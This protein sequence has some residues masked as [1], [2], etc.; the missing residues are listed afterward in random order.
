MDVTVGAREVSSGRITLTAGQ[1]STVT[2]TVNVN[3]VQV[4]ADGTAVV[5]LTT[6]GTAPTIDGRQ[7]YEIP[8]NALGEYPTPDTGKADVVKLISVGS[9]V[10]RVE[11][12]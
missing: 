9:P 4:W 11:R 10:V 1:V 2:F 3:R 5:Y 8:G 7:C 6:D 12:V